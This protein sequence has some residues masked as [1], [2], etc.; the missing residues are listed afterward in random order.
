MDL[1]KAIGGALGAVVG[2][3]FGPVGTLAGTKA[4]EYVGDAI[5]DAVAPEAPPAPAPKPMIASKTIWFNMLVSLGLALLT[6][7]A[8]YQWD[9]VVSPVTAII[10]VNAANIVLRLVSVGAIGRG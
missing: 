4:G 7:V 8:G 9:Q 6:W 3:V 5:E 2:T 1:G 10:I